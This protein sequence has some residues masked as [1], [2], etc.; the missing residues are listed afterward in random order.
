METSSQWL[1]AS[2]EA[3]S[4][5]M[6]PFRFLCYIPTQLPPGMLSQHVID[7]DIMSMG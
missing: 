2:R 4:I 1:I 5:T 7:V 6:I 3:V